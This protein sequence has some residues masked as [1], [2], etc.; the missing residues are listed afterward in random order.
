[1]TSKA[2][3]KQLP[4]QA[5][6]ATTRDSVRAYFD[7]ALLENQPRLTD[8]IPKSLWAY[9][10]MLLLGGISI[11]ACQQAFLHTRDL[12]STSFP[13]HLFEI[14]GPGN[15]ASW[16]HSVTLLMLAVGATMVYLLRRHK[17]DDY[18]GRYRLWLHLALF[19]GGLSIES[20]TGLHE[21]LVVPLAQ[22]DFTAP[23]NQASVWAMLLVALGAIYLTIR[24]L[25]EFKSRPGML[26][27]LST[28]AILL[29][30]A[31]CSRLGDVIGE[32]A[33]TSEVAQSSLVLSGALFVCLMTWLNAR[34]IYL[35]AQQGGVEQTSVAVAKT[36]SS[37]SPVQVNET[38][39][40][41]VL[42]EQPVE[43]PQ[44]DDWDELDD[45]V[46]EDEAVVYEEYEDV[47]EENEAD[48]EVG[49]VVYEDPEFEEE[50]EYEEEVEQEVGE[51]EQEV[52]E[53]EQYETEAEPGEVI[54]SA[55]AQHDE[56]YSDSESEYS[57]TAYET[58]ADDSHQSSPLIPPQ[59]Q[60]PEKVYEPF[61]EDSFWEQYDLTK[62]SRK[63]LKTMRKKLNRL[64]R[65]H[66]EKQRAA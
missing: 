48:Q 10:A 66:A 19:A 16:L 40:D 18:S 60:Q 25:V 8:L 26:V 21:I 59:T 47:I 51:V 58:P 61:D 53:P 2:K 11:Y 15:V 20:A 56:P 46:V 34:K 33:L 37:A 23:W 1:M 42:E 5:T 12:D 28:S 22:T 45:E 50:V 55:Y 27:L 17:T 13:T 24:L 4:A 9:L 32:S 35:D 63:Q 43:D 38:E 30:A 7:N 62:M 14:S 44:W 57:P 65:K 54:Y 41:S 3:Q 39:V 64:K 52:D 49:E 31:C 29:I 36:Q 6:D